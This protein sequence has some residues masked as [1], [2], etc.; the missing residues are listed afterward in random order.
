MF[1]LFSRRVDESSSRLGNIDFN[2]NNGH[3]LAVSCDIRSGGRYISTKTS[4]TQNEL[5][6]SGMNINNNI[7]IKIMKM[8]F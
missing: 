2:H 4:D 7:N 1:C 5:F 8:L 3:Q 6:H